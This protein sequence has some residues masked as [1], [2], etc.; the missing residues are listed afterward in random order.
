MKFIY[1]II[2]LLILAFSQAF[3]DEQ[4][5]WELHE[6]M[7]TP[8]GEHAVVAINDKIYVIGGHDASF[9]ALDVVEVYDTKNDIWS[10]LSPMPKALHHTGIAVHE[11]KIYVTGGYGQGWRKASNSLFIYEPATDKWTT[12]SSMPTARGG[13]IAEIIGNTLYAV[14]GADHFALPI[15]EAYDINSG[16]WEKKSPMP[17]A[18]DHLKSA[19][20][21]GKMYVIGGRDFSPSRN[22][23]SNE[24]YD[25]Q[26]DLEG[27]QS[28]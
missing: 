3:A 24:M 21:N 22:L 26:M 8:K 17:T 4:E 9:T 18:R 7:P 23:D 10:T 15:N 1:F 19:A 28:T 20:I 2:P 12:G 11:E 25:P 5:I 14:G 13:L 27:R 6:P 16:I